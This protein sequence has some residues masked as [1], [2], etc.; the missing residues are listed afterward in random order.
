MSDKKKRTRAV[1]KDT[2]DEIRRQARQGQGQEY[3]DSGDAGLDGNEDGSSSDG[4]GEN[5]DSSEG[6]DVADDATDQLDQD[7]GDDERNGQDDYDSSSANADEG[8]N[9]RE[10]IASAARTQSINSVSEGRLAAREFARTAATEESDDDGP[11]LQR[12]KSSATVLF[13]LI[14]AGWIVA[15]GAFFALRSLQSDEIT[16]D[17]NGEG[18]EVA[19][20]PTP[21]PSATPPPTA[22]PIQE[23]TPTP[24]PPTP[25]WQPVNNGPR[26]A[27]FTFTVEA[28]VNEPR[29]FDARAGSPLTPQIDGSPIPLANPTGSGA[30]LVLRVVSGEPTDEW[31]QVAIPGSSDVVWIASE[32]FAWN[33]TER[34]IQVDIATNTLVV[35]EG[36]TSIFETTVATGSRSQVTPQSSTFVLEDASRFGLDGAALFRLASLGPNAGP[37][38]DGLPTLSIGITDEFTLIGNYITDGDILVDRAAAA[39]LADLIDPGA[40]VEIFGSPPPP[41]PTPAP[42][43]EIVSGPPPVVV[44]GFVGCGDAQGTPPNCYRVVERL[45]VRGTCEGGQLELNDSCVLFA[46]DPADPASD[47]LGGGGCPPQAPDLIGGRCYLTIGPV[48][49]LAGP[50]PDGSS[51]VEGECRVP[52]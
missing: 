13:A 51:D 28:I 39:E 21:A 52:A 45:T 40:K 32:D 3:R 30:P 34:L 14:A 22:T 27:P 46:G 29:F 44:D 24:V 4:P 38:L 43:P 5:Y 36:N 41:T 15:G 50:C 19:I 48:P 25:E 35:F 33:S 17:T 20:E 47:G 10:T 11:G 37:D 1:D 9:S 26:S 2:L 42:T 12:K 23:S 6:S 18:I 49:Q 16:R 31:A 7:Y 8:T